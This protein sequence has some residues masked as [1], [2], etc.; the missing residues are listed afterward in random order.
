MKIKLSYSLLMLFLVSGSTIAQ[1][2]QLTWNEVAPGV[3]KGIV[4]KPEEYDLLKASG[5][6]P[7]KEV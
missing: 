5:S 6:I 7:N 4:G 2:P 3:W 1:N